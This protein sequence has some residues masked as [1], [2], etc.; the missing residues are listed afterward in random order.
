[1]LAACEAVTA[2]AGT[3][4]CVVVA[5]AYSANKIMECRNNHL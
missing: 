1:L 5:T 4:V 3:P 2:L